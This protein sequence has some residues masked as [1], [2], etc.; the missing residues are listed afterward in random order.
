MTVEELQVLI[1]ADTNNIRKELNNVQSS[2]GKLQNKV[3][4]TSKGI[5]SSVIKGN[6][7]AKLVATTVRAITNN[8]SGAISRLDTLNNFP[9]V[10]SNLGVSSQD[11]N[12]SL[13]RLNQGLLGLPTTLDDAVSSVQRLTS[14]NGNVK[15]STEMFLA[16]NN[17]ILAG[18]ASMQIQSSALEQ[19]SQA[20]AKGKP[21]MMEWRTALT[22]MP[23]QLKQVAIAMGYVDANQLGEALRGGTVSM[24]DFMVKLVQLNRNG[25]NGFKS[26]EEQAANSTGGVATSMTNVKTAITRG[27]ADIMNAIGQ[28]NIA[29]FFQGI[30][31][32]INSVIPYVSAFVKVMMMAVSFVGRLFKGN[33]NVAKE[34]ENVSNS[35]NSVGSS[36]GVA[37]KG[38]DEATGS[39]KKLKK[40]LTGLAGFD[41]MTVLKEHDNTSGG[42]SST[43]STGGVGALG[44]IDMSAFDKLD[45]AEDKVQKIVDKLLTFFK[46]LQDID[47]MPL[48]K[49]FDNL[50]SAIKP[51][52][53]LINDSLKKAY[54]KV[55]V[56]LAK[57]TIEKA[58]PTFFNLLAN[59]IK[60]LTPVIKAFQKVGE[61][62]YDKFLL[63]IAKWTGNVIINAL[64]G[65]SDALGKLADKINSNK[66]AQ[67]VLEGI[68]TAITSVA[69]AYGVFKVAWA[70]G[71][72]IQGAITAF[73][74]FQTAVGA[75]VTAMSVMPAAATLIASQMTVLQLAYALCT[76]QLTLHEVATALA[77]KA[78]LLFNAAM[79]A[80]PIGLVIVAVAALTAG[81]IALAYALNGG[82]EAQK[83]E[84]EAM[85]EKAQAAADLKKSYEDLHETQQQAIDSGLSE[86][87]HTQTLANQLRELADEKGNVA[88]KDRA[89]AEFILGELNEALGTEYEMVDGQIQKYDELCN[90]IDKAIEKKKLQC[91][92]EAREVEY[93]QALSKW[94]DIVRQKEEAKL[95]LE[96]AI[97]DFEEDSSRANAERLISAQERYNDLDATVNECARDIRTYEDAMTENL[98]G[99]TEEAKNLL[100]NKQRSFETFDSTVEKGAEEQT[101][102]L[103]E[104]QDTAL[105]NLTEYA[106]N[107]KAGVE[108]YTLDGLREAMDYAEKAKTEYAKVGKN[109]N[110]G[111]QQGLN[112]TKGKVTGTISGEMTDINNEAQRGLDEH[113]PSRKFYTYGENINQGLINGLNSNSGRV[114]STVGSIASGLLNRFKNILGIH[115]PSS[116][117]KGFAK[118]TIQGYVNGI[119]ENSNLAVHSIENMAKDLTRVDIE[120]SLNTD[121]EIR[122]NVEVTNTMSNQNLID[123]MSEFADKDIVN[124]VTVKIGEDTIISKV[125]KGIQDKN[126]ETNGGAFAL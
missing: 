83:Q 70:A 77:T 3:N 31:R 91:L 66:G 62:L 63:P 89:R 78:Q 27:L 87:Q 114:N 5:L 1:T 116:V 121:F 126:F 25:V 30:A 111:L 47:F 50:Y 73:V 64:K 125:I 110:E 115:S 33:S 4:N 93:R 94:T 61:W 112:E 81:V 49:S 8:I 124:N 55:L 80:N 95:E 13:K 90:T 100:M 18:G 19:L 60:V 120:P 119:D 35:L 82:T 43:G 56:P 101:R 57:F 45:E 106:K 97:N 26:F 53:K 122:R 79:S 58:L 44:N 24:N 21:D 28:S 11:A 9:K 75:C 113:S 46:P 15:A 12:A 102:I 39:A 38:I 107:Y 41:D 36:G 52:G 54:E 96:K 103:K 40:E 17:A 98:K 99:N 16:L 108:G 109:I 42:G 71:L 68:A 10:M 105:T 69:I 74:G 34:S 22:A 67:K 76:G 14:S 118:N 7:A 20:Y 92:F 48:K 117:F 123:K 37:A 32:A 59:A 23:A 84:A 29:G 85:K 6:I 104:Q 2:L 86:L 72:A 65:L 88:E 51:V